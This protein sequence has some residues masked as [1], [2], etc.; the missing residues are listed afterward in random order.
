MNRSSYFASPVLNKEKFDN[1][2]YRCLGSPQIISLLLESTKHSIKLE[3]RFEAVP[4][5]TMDMKL[6]CLP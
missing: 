3:T 6:L 2:E 5:E 4:S 1:G